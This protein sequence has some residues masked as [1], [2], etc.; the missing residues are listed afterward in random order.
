MLSSI[1]QC[2]CILLLNIGKDVQE[3]TD[4]RDIA[5]CV[6]LFPG[7]FPHTRHAD[8]PEGWQLS[9]EYANQE[10]WLCGALLQIVTNR[11]VISLICN[12]KHNKTR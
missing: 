1:R 7:W 4:Y 12:V 8:D 5:Y 11:K 6:L 3:G 9:T 10:V 2:V